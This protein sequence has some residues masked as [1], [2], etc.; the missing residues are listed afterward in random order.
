MRYVGN[1]SYYTVENRQS[2][3]TV[4]IRKKDSIPSITP[5]S[6]LTNISTFYPHNQ[7]IIKWLKNIMCHVENDSYHTVLITLTQLKTRQCK[8]G[9]IIWLKSQSIREGEEAMKRKNQIKWL[10]SKMCRQTNNSYQLLKNTLR[11]ILNIIID[12]LSI[13]E[14]IDDI[15]KKYQTKWLQKIFQ[16]RWTIMNED[17]F[18]QTLFSR[19]LATVGRENNMSFH[20][21]HD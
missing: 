7:I 17:I 10:K 19:L 1:D 2:K 9:R 5:T 12:S 11:S 6:E 8:N 21:F 3:T 15:K 4:T 14:G 16:M 13:R 20:Y 18:R